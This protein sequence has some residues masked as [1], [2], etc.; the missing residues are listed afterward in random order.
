MDK[1]FNEQFI[2]IGGLSREQAEDLFRLVVQ[3]G[4]SFKCRERFYCP[5]DGLAPEAVMAEPLPEKPRPLESVLQELATSYLP[6]MP[7]FGSPRFLG[8]PDAGNST[9][10][11]AGAVLADFLN[12]NLINSTFCSRIA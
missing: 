4:L 3:L 9:A 6:G 1:E 11:I 12:V 5:A 7:N 8:F 10:G 2:G